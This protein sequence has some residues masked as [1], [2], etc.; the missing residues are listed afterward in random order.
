MVMHNVG[1]V[2]ACQL[3]LDAI[4]DTLTELVGDM[5]SRERDHAKRR[6]DEEDVTLA[7]ARQAS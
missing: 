3:V 4:L 7:V 2:D 6:E 5:S 1:I